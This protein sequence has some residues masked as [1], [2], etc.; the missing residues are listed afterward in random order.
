MVAIIWLWQLKLQLARV[1]SMEVFLVSPYWSVSHCTETSLQRGEFKAAAVYREVEYQRKQPER[2]NYP[3]IDPVGSGP[4]LGVNGWKSGK[5]ISRGCEHWSCGRAAILE[6]P[7]LNTAAGRIHTRD[8]PSVCPPTCSPPV[9]SLD[10]LELRK[11]RWTTQWTGSID[12]LLKLAC[13]VSPLAFLS[14]LFF[15]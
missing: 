4:T 14:A 5:T 3:E 12:S 15:F 7:L 1:S 13:M 2:L 6:G 11:E 9:A 10:L 8:P